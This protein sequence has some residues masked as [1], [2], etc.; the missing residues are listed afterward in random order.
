MS[1]Q[2]SCGRDLNNNYV[3]YTN[4]YANANA[5]LDREAATSG[6]SGGP[7]RAQLTAK[8]MFGTVGAIK[9]LRDKEQQQQRQAAAARAGERRN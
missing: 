9:E 1:H 8:V 4:A 3:S 2:C 5:S 6:K 7:P